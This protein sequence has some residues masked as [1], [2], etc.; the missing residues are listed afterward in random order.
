MIGCDHRRHN[1]SPAAV[2]CPCSHSLAPAP[3]SS[4]SFSSV[5]T[6]AAIN[7]PAVGAGACFAL[8]CDIRVMAEGASLGLTFSKLSLHPGMGATHYLP[9]LVGPQTAN[10]MLLT[11]EMLDAST[12]KAL[13]VV[14]EVAEVGKALEAA[15]KIA[16]ELAANHNVGQATLLKTLRLQQ[17]RELDNN[18]QREADA[19]AICYKDPVFRQKVLDMVNKAKK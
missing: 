1:V 17:D 19:Q 7:G 6:V 14:A 5:P 4:L 9:R 3:P 16:G 12:A 13:G 11:G 10:K 8:A 15:S 18:L 2:R